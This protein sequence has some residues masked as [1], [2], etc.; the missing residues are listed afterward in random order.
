MGFADEMAEAEAAYAEAEPAPSGGGRLTDGTHQTIITELRVEKNDY[1]FAMVGRFQNDKGSI[2]KWWTLPPTDAQ[3]PYYKTD[4]LMLGYDGPL[5]KLEEWCETEAAIGLICEIYIK[6]KPGEGDRDYINVYINRAL[7]R[8]D[9][10]NFGGAQTAA[11]GTG[12]VD[13]DIPF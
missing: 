5:S 4:W 13:D 10:D 8:G 11:A 3:M 12:A 2:R 1:G 9:L 6:T 7:G